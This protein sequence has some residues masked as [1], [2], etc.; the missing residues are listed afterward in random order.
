M[1]ITWT[2]KIVFF[3]TCCIHLTK[4]FLVIFLVIYIWEDKWQ[5]VKNPSL[6][7][8]E[9]ALILLLLYLIIIKDFLETD[10]HHRGNLFTLFLHS[11]L[12]GM[13][14][15]SSACEVPMNLWEK[16]QALVDRFISEASRLVTRGR[17]VGK[18]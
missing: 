17:S 10:Q 4:N 13:C 3:Y 12:M 14:L 5:T 16:C 6:D 11:P 2:K 7:H 1:K 18:L 15:V 8:K 9:R